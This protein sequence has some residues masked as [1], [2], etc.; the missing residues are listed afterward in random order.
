MKSFLMY[1]S[2]ATIALATASSPAAA[3]QVAAASTAKPVPVAELVKRVDIPYEEFT[4]PNGLRVIVHTDRKAP[5]VAVSTWYDV[6]S[7]HEP[8]GKT[9]FAHLFEHLM[10]NGSENAPGDFFEP[11]KQVGATDFNGTTSFDRTNYFETV[12]RPALDRALFLESDRMGYLLGAITQGVLD[13]QRGVVQNEKRQGDNR[14]YGLV[15]YKLL[16]ELLAGSPYGHNVIGSMADLDAASLDDVKNWFRAHYGPNNAVLV[17]AGDVDAKEARPLVEKYFAA[18]PAGPKSVLPKVEVPTLPQAKTVVMKDRVAATMVL[19][20]WAVPGLN[21]PDS[22][23]L[24]VF[25]D[26]LG[27]LA[28]SRLDNALVRKEKLAVQVSAGIQSMAQLGMFQVQAIVKPGVDANL[29]AKR[30]D[31][32]VADLIRNGPTADEVQRVA[33]TAVSGR[34]SGLESVGGFG[35][36]AV[37]LASGELYSNNPGFFK[38]QLEE[39]A[40]VTPAQVQA[41]GKKWL[42]RPALTIMVEPGQREAYQ[43][44]A[45]VAPA[46]PVEGAQAEPF[47]GTR[48]ALPD[49]AQIGDLDFPDVSRSKLSNGVEIVYANRTAVPVTQVV[50]SFDAG[51]VADPANKLGTQNL[52]LSL[53]DE[54]TTSKD[55]IAIAEARERLGASISTG[56]SSDRTYLSVSAPSP[57]LPGA[58]D[59]FAD[60]V[61]NPAFA[62]DEVE[63]LRATQLTGIAAE[64]TDPQGL[65]NRALPPLIYGAGNPYVK[66]AAGG[67]DPEAV[68]A[69]T[70]DDLLAF[71]RAWIRPDKAKIFVV[72]DRPL[73]DVKAALEARFGNWKG[74]GA[75]GVK[76]FTV[77]PKQVAPK[78]VLVDRPDSPQSLILAAQMTQLDPA[79]ELLTPLTANQVLGAGF[80]SRI[81]MELRENKH[82]SYGAR[83]GYDWL[84][85]AVP[86]TIA[87]PVQ[88]DR[89][90]DSIKAIQQQVGDFL[91]SK[92]VTEAELTREINGTTRELAGRFE[93]SGAVLSAM[94]QND[95]RKRPDNFY[96]TVTQKY[97]SMTVAQ[98]DAAARAALDP[99]KFVWVVVGDAAK[100]KPQLDSLGLPV[101]VVPAASVAGS[102]ATA[103]S[104]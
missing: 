23:P 75:A 36:K 48:G 68:K 87:A 35:G 27:G 25:G 95:L 84:E 45:A 44:A 10:F 80:L 102:A 32:I 18:I 31:E 59:L 103:A 86:Y 46:K 9:G 12:P 73:A 17:L 74:I 93:T 34:I 85:K 58:L 94:Q 49:V 15:Y 101:E 88:A 37:A 83:G 50:M 30:L 57:N 56:S 98:L 104:K 4:L 47:K 66:L 39:T 51:V 28:S 16:E 100:V 76:A 54:G 2:A 62:P 78:I 67:G 55:S 82:W 64:L 8:K 91:T 21:D 5:I 61:R 24:D 99:K 77:A 89:T 53:L 65:A 52:V 70:R 42:S 97:R 63:R 29:V 22:V 13:E 1:C 26:V 71:Y 81:N 41:A 96:D 92:G 69:L 20:T 79:S 72:S 38:K 33:T 7:K 90:G 11:L 60:V 3:Q 14:P 6:G 40:R 19:R 43:E